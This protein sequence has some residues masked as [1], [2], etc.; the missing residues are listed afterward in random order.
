MMQRIIAVIEVYI[1]F[2]IILVPKGFADVSKLAPFQLKLEKEAI[3]TISGISFQQAG[4]YFLS[5]MTVSDPTSLNSK[6]VNAID[7]FAYEYYS[8]KLS[9]ISDYTKDAVSGLMLLTALSLLKN[10]RKENINAFLT[11]IVM[12]VESETLIIGLTKC[13]KGLSK[14]PRPYAYNTDLPYEK[15]AST[16]ASLSFWSGHASLAFMTAVFTGYVFQNRHPGSRL[17]MSVWITGISFATA[18]SV[19]RVQS[20]NHF[21]SD[22]VIGASVGSFVGWV[23]PWLHKEKSHS[24]SLTTNVAGTTGLGMLYHF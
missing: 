9:H 6:T 4:D 22:V 18:T 11:D 5:R 20:G 16:N 14:R 21:P 3:L 17:I 19:L 23:I 24:I 13:A 10:G 7:R 8:K 12:F 15:R 2:A 1:F